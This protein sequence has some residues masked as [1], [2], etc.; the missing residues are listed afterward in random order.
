MLRLQ[1]HKISLSLLSLFSLAVSSNTNNNT[2]DNSKRSSS[3]RAPLLLLSLSLLYVLVM[4]IQK[5][6]SNYWR[7]FVFLQS[8]STRPVCVRRNEYEGV[9]SSPC[10][11]RKSLLFVAQKPPLFV[12]RRVR[13]EYPR[14]DLNPKCLSLH[15]L[16]LVEIF[17]L[18]YKAHN[19]HTLLI[20]SSWREKKKPKRSRSKRKST[21]C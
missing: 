1:T 11:K 20:L 16:S 5:Y 2:N 4:N 19:T 18:H 17:S 3:S 15:L 21:N 7:D 6:Y 13:L 8:L 14:T 9:Y 10:N 12:L